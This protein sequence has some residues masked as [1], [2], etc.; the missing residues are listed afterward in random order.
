M[1]GKIRGKS[2][3]AIKELKKKHECRQTGKSIAV[4]NKWIA[5]KIKSN[6]RSSCEDL[7]SS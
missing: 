1:G 7:C 3:F 4:N 6:C 2:G 5:E